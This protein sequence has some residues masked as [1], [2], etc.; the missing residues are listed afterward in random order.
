MTSSLSP[1][2]KV[3]EQSHIASI[4]IQNTASFVD[5][6]IWDIVQGSGL[7]ASLLWCYQSAIS[8]GNANT[9]EQVGACSIAHL[10][11]WISNENIVLYVSSKLA[12]A[13]CFERWGRFGCSKDGELPH[14][15]YCKKQPITFCH[16]CIETQSALM[17]LHQ[18][19][20][21][22]SNGWS[23]PWCHS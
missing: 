1:Q 5:A 12:Y 20:K 8:A 2:L 10:E 17:D 19:Y 18:M 23:P 22:T 16:I 6:G 15:Q 4:V 3:C 13:L 21:E 11:Y 9:G 7:L 14:W